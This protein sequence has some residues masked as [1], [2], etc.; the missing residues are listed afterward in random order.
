[1]ITNF[2]TIVLVIL[3]LIIAGFLL[4]KFVKFAK[5]AKK[6]MMDEMIDEFNNEPNPLIPEKLN[7]NSK[8]KTPLS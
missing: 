4:V 5:K 3:A 6:E 7:S 1:M 8:E 2:N